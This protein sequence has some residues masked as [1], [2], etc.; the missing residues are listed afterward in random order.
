MPKIDHLT[1]EDACILYVN[2]KAQI[3]PHAYVFES[4]FPVENF[5]KSSLK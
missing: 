5:K 1:C 2:V 3:N 4:M